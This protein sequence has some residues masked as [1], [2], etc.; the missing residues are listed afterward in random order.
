MY[1]D[2]L[3]IKSINSN[4]FRKQPEEIRV[5]TGL[6]VGFERQFEC[7]HMNSNYYLIN[8]DYIT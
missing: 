8:R 1:I 6:L 5:K 2:I 7:A 3:D 4:C